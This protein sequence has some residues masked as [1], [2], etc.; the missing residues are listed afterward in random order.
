MGD[1]ARSGTQH[2]KFRILVLY[3]QQLTFSKGR[4]PLQ[5]LAHFVRLFGQPVHIF[6]PTI[7]IR[8]FSDIK[9]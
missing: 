9:N 2:P 6:R 4:L 3:C 1:Y 8:P 7:S 5:R